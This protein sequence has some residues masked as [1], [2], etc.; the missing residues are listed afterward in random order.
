MVLQAGSTFKD[1]PKAPGSPVCDHANLQNSFFFLMRHCCDWQPDRWRGN[2]GLIGQFPTSSHKQQLKGGG[3]PWNFHFLHAW[4]SW[5]IFPE[6][7]LSCYKSNNQAQVWG[8]KK[9]KRNICVFRATRSAQSSGL[10]VFLRINRLMWLIRTDGFAVWSSCV[11]MTF[12][13]CTSLAASLVLPLSLLLS[14]DPVR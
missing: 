2:V 4:L 13:S 6:P 3:E 14:G 10:F 7:V 9:K 1:Q 8:K 11:Y 12:S 5:L